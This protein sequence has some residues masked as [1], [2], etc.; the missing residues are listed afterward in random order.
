MDY[1]GEMLAL[2]I[3]RNN[4]NVSKLA[5]L[6][7]VSR[8][9]IYHWYKQKSIPAEI[10]NEIGCVIDYDFKSHSKIPSSNYS[11]TKISKKRIKDITYIYPT[12]QDDDYEQRYKVLLLKIKSIIDAVDEENEKNLSRLRKQI[13]MYIDT[14]MK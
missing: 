13:K 12:V 9:T 11:C 3:K 14:E 6:M 1:S 8:S 5:K 4:I 7:D 2:V 10:I